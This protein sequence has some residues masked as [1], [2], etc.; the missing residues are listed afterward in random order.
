MRLDLSM[1]GNH[2]MPPGRRHWRADA[3]SFALIDQF[4]QPQLWIE[5]PG[6]EN[7]D[8]VGEMAMTV[9]KPVFDR[10][11]GLPVIPNAN[12]TL[13]GFGLVR[14]NGLP[15]IRTWW[16]V[17]KNVDRTMRRARLEL[18]NAKTWPERL[19]QLLQMMGWIS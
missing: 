4:D 14:Q 8:V 1:I 5:G 3:S 17:G 2:H 6:I 9:A 18:F 11:N 15:M 12:E 16:A 7:I 13:L 19:N 10:G